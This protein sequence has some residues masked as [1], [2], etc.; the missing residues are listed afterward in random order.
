MKSITIEITQD[1]KTIVS[2]L[3]NGESGDSIRRDLRIPQGTFAIN[4]KAIR[5]KFGVKNTTELV[6]LFLRE[7][8][9]K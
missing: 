4:L 6:A 1:E 3:A 2:R 5:D 8:I 7:N 9:I